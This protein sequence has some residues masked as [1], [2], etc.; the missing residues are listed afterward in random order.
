[1]KKED[2]EVEDRGIKDARPESKVVGIHEGDMR[3]IGF[4]DGI[5]FTALAHDIDHFR[6]NVCG[7]DIGCW[8]GVQDGVRHGASATSVVMND[9][10]VG[11]GGQEAGDVCRHGG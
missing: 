10:V 11:K 9:S 3:D 6:V 5:G 8:V 7:T 1:M 4:P 2:A